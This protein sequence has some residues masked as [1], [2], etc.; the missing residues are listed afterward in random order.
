[1]SLVGVKFRLPG[2]WR[3][4]ELDIPVTIVQYLGSKDGEDWFLIESKDGEVTGAPASQ[5]FVDKS[6][7]SGIEGKC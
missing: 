1:M 2:I 3:I 6:P 4:R 5:L 7:L